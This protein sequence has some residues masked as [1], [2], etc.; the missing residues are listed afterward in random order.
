MFNTNKFREEM[1]D[2]LDAMG[3]NFQGKFTI[4]KIESSV[5]TAQIVINFVSS[6]A[7]GESIEQVEFNKLCAQFGFAK[8]DYGARVVVNGKG[9][10]LCGFN[11]RARKNA[12]LVKREGKVY[13]CAPE[14]VQKGIAY[15]KS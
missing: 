8:E 15:R 5:G 14:V 9:Y 13:T 7:D 12:C 4:E 1:T 2:V 10:T 6:E 11:P 3:E